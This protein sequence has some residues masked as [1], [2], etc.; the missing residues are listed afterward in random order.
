MA[1]NATKSLAY[2]DEGTFA[3]SYEKKG[4]CEDSFLA[5]VAA[6]DG[7]TCHCEILMKMYL[8]PLRIPHFA[9]SLCEWK[10]S[11]KEALVAGSSQPNSFIFSTRCNVAH[12][13]QTGLCGRW[14]WSMHC[15]G[16]QEGYKVRCD[17]VSTVC[18][19]R[20]CN[21][22]VDCQVLTNVMIDSSKTL[23]GQRVPHAC[24]CRRRMSC[25]DC[26][27]CRHCQG[28]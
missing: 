16:F 7:Y 17:Q 14:L 21:C 3:V 18:R 5:V 6:G 15:S 20:A 28:R 23:I 13:I 10:E 1:P 24:A 22:F 12:W 19:N 11:P 4:K 2:E 25:D 26:G 27:R 8:F 9:H